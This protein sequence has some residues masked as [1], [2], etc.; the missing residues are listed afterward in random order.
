[1]CRP[2]SLRDDISTYA[3]YRRVLTAWA[4]ARRT[5]LPTLRCLPEGCPGCSFFLTLIQTNDAVRTEVWQN[6]LIPSLDIT[7][8]SAGPRRAALAPGLTTGEHYESPHYIHFGVNGGAPFGGRAY[9]GCPRHWAGA[10]QS[11]DRDVE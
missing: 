10:E 6:T 11:P 3:A 7:R 1:M 2:R 9:H 8:G 4:P 5:P